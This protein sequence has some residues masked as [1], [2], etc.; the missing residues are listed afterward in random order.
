MAPS[1]PRWR[2]AGR[3]APSP[4]TRTQRRTAPASR[5]GHG[6]TLPP[7]RR[8]MAP[9]AQGAPDNR[10]RAP[11][12]S[13][14]GHRVAVGGRRPGSLAA[15]AGF[16][17]LPFFEDCPVRFGNRNVTFRFA[18][19]NRNVGHNPEKRQPRLWRFR[20]RF[21]GPV[22]RTGCLYPRNGD[23]RP[24][25]RADRTPLRELGI[26]RKKPGLV[27]SALIVNPRVAFDFAT[28]GRSCVGLTLFEIRK[29]ENRD[30]GNDLPTGGKQEMVKTYGWGVYSDALARTHAEKCRMS[31]HV[32]G[33][34]PTVMLEVHGFINLSFAKQASDRV[35]P[36]GDE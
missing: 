15:P 16:R 35:A 22:G 25:Q 3:N 9:V 1:P 14:R 10:V 26:Q 20:G 36:T 7:V 30:I 8:V 33:L 2:R 4:P 11:P 27:A 17:P 12:T 18:I 34:C 21:R 32:A 28:V 6:G 23:T 29:S 19:G 31:W 13:R 24:R 5:R